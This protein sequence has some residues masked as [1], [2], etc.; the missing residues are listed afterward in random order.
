VRPEL[1][2]DPASPWLLH[3]AAPPPSASAASAMPAARPVVPRECSPPQA[4]RPC[5]AGVAHHRYETPAQN[6]GLKSV[7]LRGP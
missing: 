4:G 2:A 3:A 5:A 7:G 1:S 6:R